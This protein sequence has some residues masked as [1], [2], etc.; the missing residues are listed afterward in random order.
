MTVENAQISSPQ[1]ESAS[2]PVEQANIGGEGGEQSEDDAMGAIF[3]RLSAEGIQDRGEDGKFK[4]KP[5]EGGEEGQ[6]SLEG[7]EGA[8]VEQPGSTA[9]QFTSA[10]A[11]MPQAI[12]DQ[13]A[14]LTPEAQKAIATHQAEI[15]RKFG[16]YGRFMGENKPVIDRLA[17]ARQQMPELFDG[18]T[19]EQLAQ[20]ALELGAVQVNLNRDPVGTILQIAQTYGVLGG[21]AQA[22]TGQQPT[23]DQQ[24]VHGLQREIASLKGQLQSLGDPAA[25]DKHINATMAKKDAERIIGDFAKSKPHYAEVEASLPA[26]IDVALKTKPGSSLPDVLEAAY[27]MAVNAIPEVREKIRASEAEAAA[28]ATVAKSDPKRTEAARKAASINVKSNSNGRDKP[29]S[30]EEAM[31]DAYD[32]AMNS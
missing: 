21:V 24:L 27:D 4:A 16:E 8:E 23:G 32:R 25:I 11:H 6:A 31:A 1:I 30:E 26:F 5:G 2:P 17:T 20:G 15:D 13:W 29:R 22:L 18:M 7:D 9:E 19:P 12:K 14:N 28:R 10:P 3:D